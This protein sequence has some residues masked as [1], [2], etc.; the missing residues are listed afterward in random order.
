M[1]MGEIDQAI[2]SFDRAVRLKSDYADAFTNL[3]VALYA[4]SRADDAIV[5]C[6]KAVELSPS[7]AKARSNLALILLGTG[8][9]REGWK[10][11]EWR[12]KCN[13]KFKPRNFRRPQW[14]GSSLAGKTIL[15]HAEQGFGDTIHFCR[16]VPLVARGASRVILEC[17]PTLARLLESLPCQ[18]Q[19]VTTGQPVPS[20]DIHCPLMSLPFALGEDAVVA[21]VPYL[22]PRPRL[23]DAWRERLGPKSRKRVGI[24][25]AGRRTH[26]NDR[27]RSMPSSH[28]NALAEIR[29]IEWHSLQKHVT[30]E[31]PSGLCIIDHGSELN[32]FADSAALIANLDLVISVDTA[33]AHLAGTMGK[34]T[35]VLL[36]HVAEWRWMLE[37]EHS[38]WYPTVRL[39]RQKRWAD[40]PGVIRRVALALQSGT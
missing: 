8:H 3:G 27:N 36:P 22:H 6:R 13:P 2:A 39:F 38:P 24:A 15:L 32:D 35:W 29:E 9:F 33:V 11:H 7:F 10:E 19:I 16:Y 14:D 37:R 20:F 18:L 40:W 21:D 23:T 26:S 1:D 12:W 5:A 28:L 34:P 30:G 31:R 4:N 17:Q 25:W